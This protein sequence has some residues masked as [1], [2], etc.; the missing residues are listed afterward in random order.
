MATNEALQYVTNSDELFRRIGGI[1][2]LVAWL[3][4][5]KEGNAGPQIVAGADNHIVH[6]ERTK[7]GVVIA[8]I[9][10]TITGCIGFNGAEKKRCI[11]I[12]LTGYWMSCRREMEPFK[13]P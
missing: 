7:R 6:A 4:R 5:E 8:G 13:W 9:T 11:I 10:I 12:A 1:D 2:A 3:R